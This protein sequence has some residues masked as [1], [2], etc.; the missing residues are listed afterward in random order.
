MIGCNNLVKRKTNGKPYIYYIKTIQKPKLMKNNVYQRVLLNRK[1]PEYNF[2]PGYS[3]ILVDFVDHPSGGEKGC[4]LE[5]FNDQGDSIDVMTV[6]ISRVR[7]VC[8]I[9]RHRSSAIKKAKNSISYIQQS[10]SKIHGF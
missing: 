6:P 2:P 8:K 9:R 3:A 5:I 7:P 1:Y 10:Q 4:I